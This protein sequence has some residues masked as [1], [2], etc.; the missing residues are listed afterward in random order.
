M[1]SRYRSAHWGTTPHPLTVLGSWG[2]RGRG[3]GPFVACVW[4]PPRGD[5]TWG[6]EVVLSSSKDTNALGRG[7]LTW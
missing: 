2:V 3:A 4:P 6:G 5:L 7:N 1:P